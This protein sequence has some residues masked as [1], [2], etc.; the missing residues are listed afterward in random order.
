MS[1]HNRYY[2][3]NMDGL[4]FF[5][6][7]LVISNNSR[8]SE[9]PQ[10]YLSWICVFWQMNA[11]A[12]LFF[13]FA[14]FI[15]GTVIDKGTAQSYTNCD[16]VQNVTAGSSYPIYSPNYERGARYYP[17]TNCR[18]TARTSLGLQLVLSCQ[19]VALPYVSE[20]CI[21]RPLTQKLYTY[22][23]NIQLWIL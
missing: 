15:A 13:A 4:K 2:S 14:V 7:I 1:W 22:I 9:K 21:Q 16:Y 17:G 5:L 11:E 8:K 19:E 6:N 12:Q 18:W 20:R 3:S 23:C 10:S